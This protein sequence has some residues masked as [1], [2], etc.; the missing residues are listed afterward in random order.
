M[1]VK[2]NKARRNQTYR[3]GTKLHTGVGGSNTNRQTGIRWITSNIG[4]RAITSREMDF[5]SWSECFK[6][7]TCHTDEP[8]NKLGKH[9]Y[10]LERLYRSLRVF[11][12]NIE[13]NTHVP[14]TFFLNCDLWHISEES[15]FVTVFS[16]AEKTI[17]SLGTPLVQNSVR[18]N[19]VRN[20]KY[21]RLNVRCH[22]R[23]HPRTAK[24]HILYLHKKLYK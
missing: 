6:L 1:I 21:T 22:A 19:Y 13:I 14:D 3:G 17:R 8:F 10:A 15:F 9:V 4:R 5:N 20:E 12:S 18:S 2:I 11:K 7:S 24:V 23:A 16:W